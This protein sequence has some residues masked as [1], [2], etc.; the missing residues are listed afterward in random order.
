MK[1]LIC[2]LTVSLGLMAS[3]AAAEQM[4]TVDGKEY[5]LSTLMTSCQ[6]MTDDAAK[7]VA[8]FNDL[9]KLMAE[10][11]GGAP[12]ATVSVPDALAGLREVAQY[13]DD[14]SGLVIAGT[15]C[16]VQI[17]YYGNYYHISRRNIST[18]DLF[19]ARFDASK[20]QYDQLSK[21]QGG[22]PSLAKGVMEAGATAAIRGGAELD[23][24]KLKFA[25]RSP[26]ASLDAYAVEV[27][28]QLAARDTPTFEF[29][30][31]H[32]QHQA[33]SDDIWNAFETFVE[34]CKA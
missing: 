11:A 8:C 9:A 32:P 29:V 4:I 16:N 18:L 33:A 6:Q 5:P 7:Q 23:S 30:L 27:M 1:T 13:Q 25:P 28:D 3:S 10:Q 2:S 34:A 17:I 19:T 20:F 24:S 12:K 22:T 21:G 15:D 14:D 31:V 26:R